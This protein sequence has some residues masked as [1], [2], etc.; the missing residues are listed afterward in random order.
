MPDYGP[1]EWHAIHVH[2][3]FLGIDRG[4]D[5]SME[6]AIQSWERQHANNWRARKMLRDA[7]AQIKE[8]EKHRLTLAAERGCSVSFNDAAHDWVDRFE[9]EWRQRWEESVSKEA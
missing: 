7:E 9:R 2:K 6:E 4:Y 5:P 8:I 3:Y 1:A